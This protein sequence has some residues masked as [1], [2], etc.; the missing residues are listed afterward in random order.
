MLQITEL[1]MTGP[2]ETLYTC[3]RDSKALRDDKIDHLITQSNPT[4]YVNDDKV[5]FYKNKIYVPK[6]NTLHEEILRH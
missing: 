4:I 2:D 3:I 6:D 1:E 5:I